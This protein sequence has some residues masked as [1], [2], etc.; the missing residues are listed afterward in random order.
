MTVEALG[1]LSRGA[2]TAAATIWN[3]V[4]DKEQPAAIRLSAAKTLLQ[5]LVALDNATEVANRIADLEERFKALDQK[6]KR[7]GR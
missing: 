6:T 7:K 1:Y 5:S 3:L 4:A 2:S